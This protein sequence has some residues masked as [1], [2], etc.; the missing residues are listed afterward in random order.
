MIRA[1]IMA[2]LVL[3]A[4]LLERE[5][6]VLNGLALAA[7]AILAVRPVDLHD[8]GFQLSFA[9]TA[10]LVLAGGVPAPRPRG[11]PGSAA[12]SSRPSWPAR[13]RSSPCCRSP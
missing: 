1:T 7:I 2:V 11:S 13:P 6:S 5:A 3:C 12:G 4:L 8:P 9:A 10:G